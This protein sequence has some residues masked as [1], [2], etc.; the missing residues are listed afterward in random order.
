M[1]QDYLFFGSDNNVIYTYRMLH[2]S[3]LV[4]SVRKQHGLNFA[5]GIYLSDAILSSMLLASLLEDEERINLRVQGGQHFSIGAETTSQASTRGYI[6][7][8]ED[9]DVIKALDAGKDPLINYVVRTVRSQKKTNKLFE[10]VTA[11]LTNSLEEAVNDHL[12]ISYQ[13]NTKLKVSSWVDEG[14]Q[15]L[16]AFGFIYQELPNIPQEVSEEMSTHFYNLRS[17]RELYEQNSDPD[18]LSQCLIPHQTKALKSLNPK[19]ECSCSIEKS[20]DAIR[21]FPLAD[22]EDMCRKGEDLSV[23]CHYCSKIHTVSVEKVQEIFSNLSLE[24]RIN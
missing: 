21:I 1:F 12:A 13:M 2:L 7:C 10:G 16:R 4:E 9:S 17:L 11:L 22:I 18:V 15:T 24:K 6:D 19:F 8:D 3:H 23:R 20:V 5:R 14:S